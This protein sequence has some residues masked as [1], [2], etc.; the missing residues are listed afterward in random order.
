MG[1]SRD[2]FQ[3]AIL[4]LTIINIILVIIVI[5]NPVDT[6][7]VQNCFSILNTIWMVFSKKCLQNWNTHFPPVTQVLLLGIFLMGTF[8]KHGRVLFWL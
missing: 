3:T 2:Q 4:L 5:M 1:I 8:Q 7:L 6:C